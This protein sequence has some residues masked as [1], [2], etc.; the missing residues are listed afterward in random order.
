MQEKQFCMN[1]AIHNIHKLPNLSNLRIHNYVLELVK[2]G[3]VKYLYFDGLDFRNN[4]GLPL[5]RLLEELKKQY[6][7]ADL[8]LDKTEII[9]SSKK[10][11]NKCDV[12][13]NF[14]SARVEEF[15]EGVRKFD[16]LKIF[17]LMDYFW[18]DPGSRKYQRLKDYGVD[19]LF[20]YS[21]PDKYCPYFKK[22]FPDYIGKVIPVSF[23]FSPRFKEEKSFEERKKKCVAL[24]SVNPFRP[25]DSDPINYIETA[26]FYKNEKWLHRFRRMLVENKDQLFGVMDSMLPVFPEYKD[27]KYDLVEKFNEYQMFVSDETMFYFPT[28]KTYE[29]PAS[30]AVMVCSDHPCFTDLGFIDGVN[31]IKHRQL[32][33]LDFKEK[34]NY[35]IKNEDK[36]EKIQKAGTDF[37]LKEYSHS[38]IADKLYLDISEICNRKPVSAEISKPKFKTKIVLGSTLLWIS[39]FRSLRYLKGLIK[40]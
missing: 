4:Y 2:K 3:F 1:I 6:N 36:L 7:W 29:G 8:G 12:L 17:H 33:I 25:A 10:L 26:N 39:L 11:R 21:S 31:C 32:D 15:T 19:Y 5:L 34:V 23:G 28:A 40:K 16:G 20:N 18:I 9:F 38:A 30:G 24:G 14:N 22:Y 27:F 37:V 13:L 35:Y